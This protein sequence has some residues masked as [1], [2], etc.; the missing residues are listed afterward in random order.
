[1]GL[2]EQKHSAKRLDEVRAE[3]GS[4]N[5]RHQEHESAKA[6]EG[7]PGDRSSGKRDFI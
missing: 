6:S 5:Y 2:V 3:K 7:P 1:M 4:E